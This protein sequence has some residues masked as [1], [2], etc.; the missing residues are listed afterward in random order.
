MQPGVCLVNS[1]GK[2]KKKKKNVVLLTTEGKPALAAR[3][4][5]GLTPAKA[6]NVLNQ[7]AM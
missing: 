5:T 3:T 6:H 1:L 4:S 2:V 7:S